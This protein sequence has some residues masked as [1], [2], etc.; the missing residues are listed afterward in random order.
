M[1]NSSINITCLQGDYWRHSNHPQ[2]L[3]PRPAWCSP[4]RRRLCAPSHTALFSRHHKMRPNGASVL[5]LNPFNLGLRV[6]RTFPMLKSNFLNVENVSWFYQNINASTN[7]F[8]N[9]PDF[10]CAF[11]LHLPNIA[12]LRAE[13]TGSLWIGSSWFP[14][15]LFQGSE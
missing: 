14:T 4:G 2:A 6:Q 10:S 7:T 1:L 8:S 11:W 3:C 9:T 15:G 12:L 5:H 13:H